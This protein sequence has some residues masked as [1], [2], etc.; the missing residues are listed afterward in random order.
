[1]PRQRRLAHA[2]AAALVA[3]SAP[4]VADIHVQHLVGG[5][6]SSDDQTLSAGSNVTINDSTSGTYRVFV[7]DETSESIGIITLNSSGTNNPTLFVGTGRTT[8]SEIDPLTTA[9]CKDL[10]GVAW[11]GG[12]PRL[13]ASIYNDVTDDVS[14]WHIFRIDVGGEL[15]GN[16]YHD[17]GGVTP[18]PRLG[19]ISAGSTVGAE[20]VAEHGD[21]HRVETMVD[22]F[23]DVISELGSID[24]VEAAL[25]FTGT[26]HGDVL[27]INGS[28]GSVINNYGGIGSGSAPITHIEAKNGIGTVRAADDIWAVVKA[29]ANGGAGNLTTLR[30]AYP[31][32]GSF[33]GELQANNLLGVYDQFGNLLERAVEINGDFDA[34]AVVIDSFDSSWLCYGLPVDRTIT[35]RRDLGVNAIV[36]FS[37]FGSGYLD[38]QVIINA[39]DDG[40]EWLGSIGFGEIPL[41]PAPY[42]ENNI[43]VPGTGANQGAVG[44]APYELHDEGCEPPNHGYIGLDAFNDTSTGGVIIR[45]YGPINSPTGD[46]PGL[47]E[48]EMQVPYSD[49]P[50]WSNQVD[51]F[52]AVDVHPAGVPGQPRSIRIKRASNDDPIPTGHY[53]VTIDGEGLQCAGVDG[54]PG[55]ATVVYDFW[56][57]VDCYE[58]TIL[59]ANDFLSGSS[60]NTSID[61][62]CNGVFDQCDVDLAGYAD[63]DE[64]GHPDACNCPCDWNGMGGVNSQDFFDFLTDFFNG[65]AD[66]NM[67]SVTNSQDFFDFLFCFFDGC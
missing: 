40:Y 59:D 6:W 1:M 25:S 32:S 15:Q 34:D 60:C 19:V 2:V 27:A 8:A 61:C 12:R 50:V 64:D 39:E 56:I 22:A 49:P 23:A 20:I 66:Y 29:N 3:C 54:L 16:V 43:P 9:G 67:D 18:A 48:V 52:F 35:F 7:D 62:N 26:W 17:G 21:I 13:Q 37:I 47:A 51:S 14:M 53:R 30:L 44:L 36:S 65:D 5:N 31:N 45:Y 42:Y 38:G 41:Y 55:P 28:I 11:S 46:N 4:A 10:G 63:K 24:E 33:H 58:D 57:A